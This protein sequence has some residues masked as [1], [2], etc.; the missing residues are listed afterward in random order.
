MKLIQT[1]RYGSELSKRLFEGRVVDS[2]DILDEGVEEPS[3]EM[4]F[5]RKLGNQQGKVWPPPSTVAKLTYRLLWQYHH[6]T[7]PPYQPNHLAKSTFANS[8]PLHRST[9]SL[10][11]VHPEKDGQQYPKL[12]HTSSHSLH[13]LHPHPRRCM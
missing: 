13:H 11:T 6:S 4:S 2:E 9:L 12:D 5:E 1:S 7:Y 3:G 10:S 8:Y